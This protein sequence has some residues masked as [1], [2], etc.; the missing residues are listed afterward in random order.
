MGEQLAW[1]EHAFRVNALVECSQHG[2]TNFAFL[3]LH[4]RKVVG[5]DTVLV[6]QGGAALHD[7]FEGRRLQGLPALQRGFGVAGEPEEEGEVEAG[8]GRIDV[9][10][11]CHRQNPLVF[12]RGSEGL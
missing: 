7:G 10:E 9:G 2:E 4:E 12:E 6:A 1:V 5:A 11:V 8:S 3:L